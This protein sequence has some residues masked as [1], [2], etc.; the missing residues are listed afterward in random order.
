MVLSLL[1]FEVWGKGKCC[2][3]IAIGE[4]DGDGVEGEIKSALV[5]ISINLDR[6][7]FGGYNHYSGC[8]LSEF[9]FSGMDLSNYDFT[10]A[11]LQHSDFRKASSLDGI[12][13]AGANVSGAHFPGDFDV[14]AHM[15]MVEPC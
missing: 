9:D 6:H 11:N 8:D 14:Q 2:E 3:G 13:L 5:S 1:V 12:R 15:K 7:R 4:V 10:N